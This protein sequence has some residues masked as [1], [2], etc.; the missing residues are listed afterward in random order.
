[1]EQGKTL[2][3]LLPSLHPLGF[4]PCRAALASVRIAHLCRL[5]LRAPESDLE[6]HRRVLL[7]L[8]GV[9][10]GHKSA[11]PQPWARRGER[12]PRGREGTCLCGASSHFSSSCAGVR[13][14]HSCG[15]EEGEVL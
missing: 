8:S 7:S 12:R 4:G 6:G 15:H 14:C 11:Q 2:P 13:S 5:F 9:A 10:R 1:M 3:T